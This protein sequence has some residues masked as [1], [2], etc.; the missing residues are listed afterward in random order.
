MELEETVKR[1][2]PTNHSKSIEYPTIK[3][4]QLTYPLTP[5]IFVLI[6]KP[7]SGK[8][9][10]IKH[11]MYQYAKQNYFKNAIVF[12]STAEINDDY[13]YLPEDKLMLYDEDTL[14]KYVDKLRDYR[15][16]N[17][18]LPP[19]SCIIID[20]SLGSVN[21]YTPK[22]SNFLACYRHYNL[23]II[24]SAQYLMGYGSSTLIRESTTC[25]F[26]FN[27]TFNKSIKGL[28]ESYGQMFD[29]YDEFYHY[30]KQITS[31]KFHVMMYLGG[32]KDK[33]N[34]YFDFICPETP[35]FK[36][37]F[38]NQNQSM[39]N[40]LPNLQPVKPTELQPLGHLHYNNTGMTSHMPLPIPQLNRTGLNGLPN[41]RMNL[42]QQP[43]HNSYYKYY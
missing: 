5:N 31:Q 36:L 17:K 16:K 14:M 41:P 32:Q 10:L 37:N 21:F 9:Y 27:T 39:P 8:S 22:F 7:G 35:P 30:F 20:D 38:K 12:S 26:M 1:E 33:E 28:Y 3:D 13:D 11:I 42:P 15:K 18:K 19:P 25:A 24:L 23:T 40:A 4:N 43:D 34:T 2:E 6:A 29:S